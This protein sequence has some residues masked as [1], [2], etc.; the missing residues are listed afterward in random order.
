MHICV[1]MWICVIHICGER[2]RER[3]SN[4][5]RTPEAKKCAHV[6]TNFVPSTIAVKVVFST[7]QFDV[8][9]N[10]LRGSWLHRNKWIKQNYE[11][12][13]PMSTLRACAQI[14]LLHASLFNIYTYTQTHTQLLI[15]SSPNS[16]C[17][18]GSGG[19]S[20]A[21]IE[22]AMGRPHVRA[23]QLLC[24]GCGVGDTYLCHSQLFY[25]FLP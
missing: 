8:D 13:V 23:R 17:T 6:K 1:L 24:A 3:E 4:W 15:Q 10:R 5:V 14:R 16:A 25:H 7:E 12:C 2:E 11:I 20:W 18:V 21:P 9:V 22:C 19:L